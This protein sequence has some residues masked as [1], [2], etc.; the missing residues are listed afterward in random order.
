MEKKNLE[1]QDYEDKK[2]QA[3]KRY[4][5]FK[6]NEGWMSAFDKEVVEKLKESEGKVVSVSIA[7]DK[8]RGFTN[9]RA[10]HGK[11]EENFHVEQKEI[12]IAP[13]RHATM[14]VSYAK[15]IFCEL[16]KKVPE[17]NINERLMNEAVKLVKQAKLEFDAL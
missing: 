11:P 2:S 6:T 15:D 9:I 5:R 14:Y 17:M 1:I 10:F 3:G 7:T 13:D 8:E 12:K 4:T 16:V